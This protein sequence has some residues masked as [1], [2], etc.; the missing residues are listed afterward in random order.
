MQVQLVHNFIS[1]FYISPINV[2]EVK[3]YNIITTN[4][5]YN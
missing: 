2:K 1:V 4:A 3:L 5:K